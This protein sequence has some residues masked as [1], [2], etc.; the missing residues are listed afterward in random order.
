M[1]YRSPRFPVYGRR[2]MVAT[3][4]PIAAQAGLEVL[5]RGG[6]AVDA[7]IA[8]SAALTVVEPTAS[9][10]GS[11]A[12]ALVWDGSELHGLDG[13][14]RAP[15]AHTPELYRDAGFDRVPTRGWLAV[16][17]PGLVAAWR[18]LH[19]R[20]G[21]LPFESLFETAVRLADEGFVVGAFT[22]RTW[23]AAATAYRRETPDPS[24]AGW[25]SMF[26]RDGRAPDAGD[27]WR[28]P[29]QARTLAAVATS[30][31][32]S[33]YRGEIA[34]RIADFAR[35]TGGRLA[36]SDL[37]AHE[38]AWVRP[39]STPYRDHEVWEL[40]APCP[41]KLVH[42]A[43][44][45]L[46]EHELA[47]FPREST[48]SY[49]LQIDAMRGALARAAP[50]RLAGT[51]YLATADADGTMVSFIQ[52]NYSG[53][54]LGF[55]SG[56][57]VPGT[58]IALQSRGAC[59]DL[60]PARPNVIAPRAK[61]PHTLAPAFLTRGGRALGP[62]GATGGPMQPQAQVQLIVNLV[63]YAMDPQAALDAPR[64]QVLPSGEVEVELDVPRDV[65]SELSARGWRL[66]PR[67]DFEVAAP[68]PGGAVGLV[69]RGDFGKGQIIRRLRGGGYAAGTDPRCAG[70][71]I[72]W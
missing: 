29:D 7:A 39:I 49:E 69:G 70:A 54:L 4:E 19:A 18:D 63:D 31:G 6:N 51:A 12:F 72:G 42:E 71:A 46:S 55:G 8:T 40:P 11:D 45:V 56:V 41:G 57:V 23:S 59:F 47:R 20:F 28:L 30:A 10:L 36:L 52:S 21:K 43:L 38:S 25:G 26:T 5:W 1:A 33:F 34:Q 64:W 37:A 68:A 9:A 27:I 17:V 14:G 66:A 2:G 15:A 22:A 61:P 67:V 53:W 32:D 24:V 44:A 65:L 50:A 16:T 60:D 13:S 35:A 48:S 3:S 58:G 62:F